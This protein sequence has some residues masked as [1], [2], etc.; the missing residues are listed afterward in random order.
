MPELL[1]ESSLVSVIS[2][3][4]EKFDSEIVGKLSK[5]SWATLADASAVSSSCGGDVGF[6]TPVITTIGMS[7]ASALRTSTVGSIV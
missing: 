7:S 5:E 3:S 2:V 1:R 4:S 6:K